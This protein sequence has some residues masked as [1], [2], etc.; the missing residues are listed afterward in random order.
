MATVDDLLTALKAADAAG[1]T[2]DAQR[3]AEIIN[4]GGFGAAPAA[5]STEDTSGFFGRT[6]AAF[7]RGLQEIPE[8]LQGVKLGA[9]AA[10]GMNPEAQA[11]IENIRKQSEA[12][13]QKQQPLS[14]EDL[15]KTYREKG[16]LEAAK[17]VPSYAAEQL[18]GSAPSIAAPLAAGAAA[19]PFLTP[20][21]GAA[22]GAGVLGLQTFGQFMRSQAEQGK[23]AEQLAPGKAA[24]GAAAMAPVMYAA[25]LL[26]LGLAKIPSKVLVNE[27]AAE[28]AS[29]AAASTTGRVVA[30]ATEGVVAQSPTMVLQTI[31][32]RWQSGMPLDNDEAINAYKEAAV[33]AATV[34][35]ILGA[36]H[37][38]V[39]GAPAKAEP[40]AETTTAAPP[41]PSITPVSPAGGAADRLREMPGFSGVTN[42]NDAFL[43]QAREQQAAAQAQAEQARQT[44]IKTASETKY[45]SDPAIDEMIRKREL[46]TLGVMPE[47]QEPA[48]PLKMITPQ[49][50]AMERA[51]NMPGFTGEETGINELLVNRPKEVAAENLKAEQEAKQNKVEEILGTTYSRDPLQ[52]ELARQR[53]M[54]KLGFMPGVPIEAQLGMY[55]QGKE[56]APKKGEAKAFARST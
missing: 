4:S 11:D 10:L 15:Q 45:S 34:G 14:F 55:P 27:A 31:V 22:V 36:G 19:T 40:T 54:E 56:R 46:A 18:V 42:P 49:D 32:D 8:Q 28:L 33:G 53:E 44:Q 6:K 9:E 47:V 3:I 52:N 5:A 30:G 35:G 25:N 50:R 26:T 24:V 17:Q 39:K 38:L 41:P 43:A 20:L 21:G 23:N 29:R 7:S 51:R 13:A 48:P 37:G 16:L 2:K 1:N 12:N